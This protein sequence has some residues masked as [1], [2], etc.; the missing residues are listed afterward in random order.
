MAMMP[1]TIAIADTSKYGLMAE[2]AG[3][4]RDNRLRDYVRY[5]RQMVSRG[6]N[7][8]EVNAAE[9][10][11]GQGLEEVRRRIDAA[12]AALGMGGNASG[13]DK[14]EK[15]LDR[16]RRLAR[17]AE[18]LAERTRERAQQQ[19]D[20]GRE[21]DQQARNDDKGQNGQNGK[22]GQNGK[23]GSPGPGPGQRPA[24]SGQGQGRVR[25]RVS[26]AK[27]SRRGRAGSGRPGRR[28]GASV[29]AAAR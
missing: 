14:Q 13:D 4:I 15:T 19:R 8:A 1:S 29:P 20:Q 16:A 9:A 24:G 28:R 10:S 11:I 2:A 25:A 6:R 26:R 17:G 7:Q 23:G 27:G 5:S 18:S 12:G 21:G 22:Q 3:V